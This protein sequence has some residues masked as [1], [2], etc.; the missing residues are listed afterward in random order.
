M[1]SSSLR[2]VLAL[3]LTAMLTACG[4][5]GGGATPDADL[6]PAGPFDGLT[7]ERD[8]RGEGLLGAVHI[9]RDKYGVAHIHATSL[10]DGAFAQG[11][12][13]AHDRLP[14]MDIL[15][16]F[17][18]GTLAELFGGLDRSVIDTDIEMRIHRMRPVAEQAWAELSASTDPTDREIVTLLQRFSDGV[19]AYASAL[20]SGLW[21]LDDTILSSFDPA[22]FE[23]WSPVDSLTLGRFQAFALSWTAPVELDLTR[24]YQAARDTFDLALPADAAAYARRGISRDLLAVTPVGRIATI[25]GF[26]N[27]T[28]DTG[29]RSDAGRPRRGR[30]GTTAAA[31]GP[32]RPHVPRE[33]LVNARKFFQRGPRTGPLGALGPHA[34][35]APRAGSNNWVVS[36]ALGGGKALLAG[37]QHLSLPN[38]SIFYPTHLIVDD[39]DPARDLD[40]MGVSF[41]GIPGIILGSNGKA[42]WVGTV[43]YHDVND[44]YLEAIAPCPGD[45]SRD[46]VAHDGGQVPIEKRTE[47][48]EIGVFGTKTGEVSVEY[49]VVPHHG[50]IIPTV[51]DQAIVPRAAGQALSV[52]YTGH[53]LTHEIRAVFQLARASNVDEAFTALGDFGYGSQNWA[54]IDNQGNIGWTTNANVP[55][56]KPAAYTWNSTSN[57]TGLAPFFVLPGDGS[58]DWE[59]FMPS[60]YVPH[61]INPPQ[62][63]LVTAN[64]DPV[65]ATFDGD[66]LNQP[67]VD[68]RPL[69]LSSVYAAG[70]RTERIANL[71]DAAAA[72]GPIDSATMAAIQHDS[73]STVGA[74]L[75]DAIVAAT[76]ELVSPG[77][78]PDVTAFLATLTAPQRAA[79]VD[80]RGRLAAWTFATPVALGAAPAGEV[81]DSVATTVFNTWMHFAISQG[82]GD[83]FTAMGEDVWVMEENALVR[84]IYQMLVE[85]T[86]LVQ[87]TT[88]SDPIVCDDVTTAGADTGC[89]LCVTRALHAALTHLA[90]PA[91]FASADATTWR[92]GTV[93]RLTLEPLFP[94]SA[95][96]LP[97]SRETNPDWIGGYPKPGDNFVVNRADQGW[98]D[99]ELRQHADGPAQRFLAEATPGQPISVRWQFPGGTV[100]NPPDPHYRD[101]LDNYYIAERHFDAPFTIPQIVTDGES[102][103][104]LR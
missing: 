53:A 51:V 69:Y 91:G 3:A 33:L 90:S 61:A 98:R 48:I 68:G 86:A 59:G 80:A 72:R 8:L 34:F 1:R 29:T 10:A 43:S 30:G 89:A 39:A 6:P 23:A 24:I 22:R 27:V 16:R 41:P 94:N 101:V 5:D 21:N 83:E 36:P 87:S 104:V 4:D 28:T 82:L 77:S 56:R 103:W 19:N 65:G 54:I 76:A 49:E 52:A 17:G 31:A 42:A 18:A 88:S 35:M 20:G 92:W 96:N 55:L 47:T 37:D 15:R 44:V 38:P 93:H 67:V 62:G 85:P 75:R 78:D 73:S 84:T 70:V 97:T 14:Q 100:F 45:A 99:L 71:L 74:K 46:C 25:D 95:L 66:P 9:A 26:P 79:L 7:L 2:P 102:R 32:T 11:Y 60:R 12:V 64:S 57:P 50:P 40:I 81:A 13:M 58:A 63:Y